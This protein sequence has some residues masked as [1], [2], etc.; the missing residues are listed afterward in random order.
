MIK[1]KKICNGRVTKYNQDVMDIL[2]VIPR[3]LNFVG[4]SGFRCFM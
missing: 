4:K 2:F 1:G 3:L